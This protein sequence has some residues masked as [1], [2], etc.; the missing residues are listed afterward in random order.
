MN[1]SGASIHKKVSSFGGGLK[2][3]AFLSILAGAALI[4]P[5]AEA[6][7]AGEGTAKAAKETVATVAVKD[8]ETTSSVGAGANEDAGCSI[9]R[10]RLFVEGEGWIVRRVTTCY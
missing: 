9:S 5:P 3:L 6:A 1:A 7:R 2:V 8:P 4:A 10:R